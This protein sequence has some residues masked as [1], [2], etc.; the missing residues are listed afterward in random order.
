MSPF[1]KSMHNEPIHPT[2]TFRHVATASHQKRLRMIVSSFA[3][4]LGCFQAGLKAADLVWT[5]D[6][7]GN[8]DTSTSNWING[9]APAAFAAGD[10]VTFDNT[11]TTDTI[12]IPGAVTPSAITVD[13]T[14]DLTFAPASGFGINGN[15]PLR[16]AGMGALIFSAT[17]TGFSGT[18]TIEAGIFRTYAPASNIVMCTG[19]IV[20]AGGTYSLTAASNSN[21]PNLDQ[22]FTVPAGVTGEIT[23]PNR[24]ALNGGVLGSGT[25]ILNINTTVSRADFQNDFT[26]FSGELRLAGSGTARIGLNKL[27]SAQPVAVPGTS[28]TNTALV[29]DGSVGLLPNTASYGNTMAIGSLAGSSA[30]AK[31]LGGSNGLVTYEIGGKNLDTSYAG[32]IETNAALTKVGTGMLTLTNAHT[33]TGATTISAGALHVTGQL[34]GASAV[35]VSTSAAFGGSGTVAGNVTYADGATLLS[36]AVASG[37]LLGMDVAG[38]VTLGSTLDISPV[39]PEG[40]LLVSGTYTLLRAA[41][42]ITGAPTLSWVYSGT[43]VS[44]V[45]GQDANTITVEITASL[46]DAPV[47][48]S[49]LTASGTIGEAFTYTIVASNNPASYDAIGLPSGLSINT[50]S[51]VISGTATAAGTSNVTISATNLGGSDS[52][53]LEI[54][55]SEPPPPGNVPAITSSLEVTGT[56]G[57]VF[58]YQIVA[59]EYPTGYSASPLPADLSIASASGLI[60]GTILSSGTS[61]IELGATN[62]VGTGTATLTL[63][64]YS[65][66]VITSATTATALVDEPFSYTLTATGEPTTFAATGLPSGLSFDSETREISGTPTVT[67]TSNITLTASNLVGSDTKTLELTVYSLAPAITS[68]LVVTGTLGQPFDYQIT[69]TNTPTSFA[70]E[71][72]PEGLSIDASGRIT[73]T[74]T[75]AGGTRVTLTASNSYGDGTATLVISII[76]PVEAG[77]LVWTGSVDDTWDKTTTNW[78]MTGASSATNYADGDRVLFNDT[79]ASGTVSISG[80]ITPASLTVDVS[81]RDLTIDPGSGGGLSGDIPIV[82]KGIGT[83]AFSGTHAAFSGT[84]TLQEGMLKLYHPTTSYLLSGYGPVV[85]TGGTLALDSTASV[86]LLF[87]QPIYVPEGSTGGIRTNRT[88]RFA[89]P[90]RGSGTLTITAGSNIE[91][92]VDTFSEFSG[93]LRV[94]TASSTQRWVRPLNGTNG[95]SAFKGTEWANTSIVLD[96]AYIEPHRQSCVSGTVVIGALSSS[97]TTE[98]L[99]SR[100]ATTAPMYTHYQIGGKNLD[101]VFNGAIE[102]KTASNPAGLIKVGTGRFTLSGKSTHTGP[103]MVSAGMLYLT[104]EFSGTTAVTVSGSAAFGGTGV[105]AG[106]VTYADD[107]TLVFASDEEATISGLAVRGSVA[108]GSTRMTVTPVVPEGVR[109][110]NGTH[111]ILEADG[112][113][114]GSPTFTWSYPADPAITADIVIVGSK[115]QVIIAGGEVAKAVI[116]SPLKADVMTGDAFTYTLTAT[117]DPSNPTQLNATDLPAG[118]SYDPSTNIISGTLAAGTY[119]ITLTASNDSGITTETLT[120]ISY[121]T[122]PPAPVITSAARSVAVINATYVYAI[123]ADNN[124]TA[125][126]ATGLPAGLEINTVTGQITG[127]AKTLGTSEVTLFASNIAGTGTAALELVVSLPKPEITKESVTQTQYQLFSHQI[128]ATNSP[129][130]YGLDNTVATGD[131]MAFPSTVVLD[132]VTGVISGTFVTTGTYQALMQATNDAGTGAATLN[133][134]VVIHPPVIGGADSAI[135]MVGTPFTYSIVAEHSPTTFA[136]INLPPG[137]S[138]NT[139]TGVISG[140][141]EASGSYLVSLIAMNT[142][143]PGTKQVTFTINGSSALTTLAGSAGSPGSADGPSSDARFNTPGAGVADQNGNLYVADTG[144]GSIR[145]IATDGTVST[146]ATGLNA[147]ASVVIDAAGAALYVAN[148]GANGIVKIDIA[149]GVATTLVLAGT[150][151]LNAPTG[152]V[153]DASGNLYVAN[154]GDHTIVKINTATCETALVA[155]ASGTPGTANATGAA[156]GFDLPMGIAINADCS[157]LYVADTGN[158]MIRRIELSTGVVETVAGIAGSTGSA[159]GST[160]IATFNT[161]ESLAVDA[162]GVIYVADTGNNTIR[163]IDTVAGTVSTFAGMAGSSGSQDGSGEDSTLNAPGGITIDSVSGEIYVLDTGNHIVRVLQAG[164]YFTTLPKAQTV[165]EGR[166]AIFTAVASGAPIPTY[167]WYKDGVAIAGAT[168]SAL[169]ISSVTRTDAGR[170]SVQATNP[171]GSVESTPVSLTVNGASQQPSGNGISDGNGGGAPGLW[172]LLVLALLGGVHVLRRRLRRRNS[173]IPFA[174]VATLFVFHAFG[175]LPLQAQAQTT[176]VVTGKVS[177]AKTGVA[178]ASAQVFVDSQGTPVLT[179]S[180]GTFRI[181]NLAPGEHTVRVAY[182]DLDDQTKTVT[183]ESGVAVHVEF[184]MSSDVYLLEKFVV[185]SE[186]E[187]QSAAVQRQRQS[188]VMKNVVATD[189]FGNLIDTNAGELLKNLPGI[190]VDY[191]GEDVGSFSIR[192]IGSDQGTMSVDGNEFANSSTNPETSTERGVALKNFSIAS[193]ESIE[194]Y[195]SPPPSS[196]AN[197]NGGVINMISKNAFDQKGRRIRIDTSMG[198]NTAALDWDPVPT[199]NRSPARSWSPGANVYYSEAFLGNRLGISLN[200]NAYE[201][202][203]FNNTIGD[204]GYIFDRPNT[205]DLPTAD[206]SGYMSDTRLTEAVSKRRNRSLTFN[207]DFKISRTTSISLKTSYNDWK[208]LGGGSVAARLNTTNNG[209]VIK[210]ASNFNTVEV[211]GAYVGMTVGGAPDKQGYGQAWSINPGVK[212]QFGGIRIDYDGYISRAFTHRA[213]GLNSITYNSPRG[214]YIFDNLQSNDGPTIRQLGITPQNDYLDLDNYSGLIINTSDSLMV[215]EKSGAKANIRIPAMLLGHPLSIRAGSSYTSWTRNRHTY[216]K[217]YTLN[218]SNASRPGYSEFYD[219][220]RKDSWE[221]TDT[222]VPN[223]ISPWKVLDYFNENPDMFTLDESTHRQSL[224]R[225]TNELTEDVVSG[226][227]MGSWQIHNLNIMA[228]VRYEHTS[229]EASGF[230]TDGRLSN[231][232]PL[233]YSMVSGKK[234]YDNWFPNVQLK[235]EPLANLIFRAAYTTS[236]GRPK[237]E[238]LL[239]SDSYTVSSSAQT[240]TIN[241]KNTGLKPQYSNNYDISVEYYLPHGGVISGGVFRKDITDFILETSGLLADVAP[242]LVEQ[243]QSLYEQYPN[244]DIYYGSAFN[245]GTAKMDGFEISYRQRLSFLPSFLKNIEFYESFSYIKP[246]GDIDVV[247]LKRKVSNTRITYRGNGWSIQAGYN[248]FGRYLR[249]SPSTLTNP[250]GSITMGNDGTYTKASGRLDLSFTYQFSRNWSLSCDWRNVLNEPDEYE[251]FGRLVRYYRAGTTINFVLKYNL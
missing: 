218:D 199:G 122:L 206:M 25:L 88:T 133:V 103:T 132:P 71:P 14:R 181:G 99:V 197:A 178:L 186:R 16:K 135:G 172:Y 136:A 155:G 75:A 118:L 140:T 193:I 145:K 108:L 69:A 92:F 24:F 95:Y 142:T 56:V 79:S 198:L 74:L 123:E 229:T 5:G 105:V 57:E 161:P 174:I 114:T 230:Q 54:T 147:P 227:M 180:D 38:S 216:K 17:N 235:Y 101:T 127:K 37:S 209:T 30:S 10:A 100:E 154:T 21:Q 232:D 64:A 60:S 149:T 15:I 67:G 83:L 237:L 204:Q 150:P 231:T 36:T 225:Y 117:S 9:A 170:Y 185:S 157:C 50:A 177:S 8:W 22:S 188:D 160:S 52:K 176:G 35:S 113:I 219:P 151:A 187:G 240:V 31:L 68:E 119:A 153:I 148:T 200:A 65:V 241:K 183:I 34:A 32:S 55:I 215:D 125:F 78:I 175:S 96:N 81:A 205:S 13:V 221:F 6:V 130:S 112:N 139:S 129:A 58:N 51:G 250:D 66:P 120:V 106:N 41:G 2:R 245:I 73:G 173:A 223:W 217:N 169:T 91:L 210:S 12:N 46:P 239:P 47:I 59:T 3:V 194:V 163:V 76:A 152:L 97:G 143:G 90:I 23:T 61:I 233:Y 168:E 19:P 49:L 11:S 87:E 222:A 40:G 33:Y 167:Q 48:T 141:P 164:P 93:E 244:Y 146:F 138:V 85:L 131:I 102:N 190:F 162:A 243:Y 134:V 182:V 126:N 62:A 246:K 4:A 249:R 202:Y 86:T 211:E 43:G 82:K 111:T 115:V 196:P 39:V 53:I 98:R 128:V 110:I 94:N 201:T 234:S 77:T 42:G 212:H 18:V 70:A 171:M 220:V 166:G 192:G 228:G 248:W 1:H 80:I 124:P 226:Y 242:D 137:L 26:G 28:W 158:S 27:S 203:R 247:N 208:D 224:Y 72:L 195:K 29:I 179:E 165:D 121:A 144:N 107:S 104:G 159:N 109:L 156:A 214:H 63:S 7:D 189:A 251:R 207:T 89:S 20:F 213:Q 116:T 236:I 84:S 45:L 191:A 44:A 184:V 238:Y